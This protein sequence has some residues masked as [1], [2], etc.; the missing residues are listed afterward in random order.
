MRIQDFLLVCNTHTQ[1]VSHGT[2][3]LLAVHIK[4][5]SDEDTAIGLDSELKDV[6]YFGACAILIINW[7]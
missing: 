3:A 7:C 6:H 1:T 4:E 5:H 2:R